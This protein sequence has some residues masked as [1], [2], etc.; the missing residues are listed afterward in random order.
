MNQN[1]EDIELTDEMKAE[2]DR[3]LERLKNGEGRSYTLAEV[4]KMLAEKRKNGS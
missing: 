1:E 3:R 4:R 2:L